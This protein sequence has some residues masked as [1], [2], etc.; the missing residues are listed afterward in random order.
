MNLKHFQRSTR[1]AATGLAMLLALGSVPQAAWAQ[2]S[3]TPNYKDADL[4]Q[5][6]EA[7]S[8][9]T[10]KNFIVD[11]R[12]K[13][14]VT[15][16]SSTPMSPAAF[17]EAFLSILQ[18][19]GFVAVP[20]GDTIKII[21]DA[22]A[23]QIPAN[24]LPSR[25]SSTSD[26]IVTQVVAV[27]NV[28]AAQLV[29]IL[30]PLIPQYGHLAAY[31]A[32][33]M[34]IISDRASNVNRV[35]RIIQR[36]DQQ[37]DES[38]DVVQ[39]QHA[40]A[41]EVVRIIN[42]LYAGGAAGAE[43]AGMPQVK[44]IA[45]ERTNSV[46][47]S[48]EASQRLRLKTL[49]AHLDTPLQSG[50][51]T[52]V[53][54][55]R[56]A[57]AEKIAAK[58]RE[59]I[60]GIAAAAMPTGGA[61]GGAPSVASSGGGDKSVT[62]WAEPQT[63]ALVVTAP[64]KV[65]RSVMAIVDRLDIRRAQ[66][67][68]EAILV[69]MSADKA[70]DLG[71]NWLIAETDS[72]GNSLPAGGFV[73]PV[74]GTGIGEIIQG[75]LDPDSIPGLPSGLTMGL[76]QI[77]SGGTSWAA[78]IRAIGGIGNTNIIAT[79]S[80]VTLDNEEAEIK[81]AQEVPFV[82]G[83][84]TSQGIP[85]T[86]GQVNP[87]QTIQR[88]EVGNILKI[89]PQINEGSSVMLKISQEASSIAASSQQVSTNDLITNKRTITTNVMVED[90]G[91]IVLGGLISDEVRESKSQ[92]PFLG[93]IPIIGE[94]F[95]TRSVDKVKT[96][97][98][99]FIRPRILR[100]GTDAA[101]ESNAKYNYIREQQ[102]GRNGGR[103]PLMP[104]ERQPTLPP[105]EQLVPPELLN[106]ARQA[107]PQGATAAERLQGSSSQEYYLPSDPTTGITHPAPAAAPT[108]PFGETATP[109]APPPPGTTP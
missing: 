58:L 30:R 98:M 45:D 105:L 16:L 94:L 61:A 13:A 67:L 70:M 93:S 21:P 62:I 20:S 96:N 6:I 33:N 18:V 42:S 32:S 51:D 36:I 29:P 78:V 57:D 34:L 74:D 59:Q 87:F 81:I 11:P 38:V 90:G 17:Y 73:Q 31:P 54:Y 76:G 46:L 55:L 4:S 64:P 2:G 92:V 89:T 25:V 102:T 84:Y 5:I 104:S 3:I 107:A 50:G 49:V 7:V 100:D 23:R 10:G 14:Q 66:V 9:V 106:P 19:H 35:M 69:E 63:N 26:E 80:I 22:N 109:P 48:G 97:L 83:Q 39:L 28:S 60:Q 47:V 44:V 103:V 88:E 68:V 91:I 75:V 12:V 8:A 95:K 27:K 101:I 15:M 56:Y 77:V 99:V 52:Q 40:S 108:A 24:D 85:G 71:V 1:L 53:R 41:A 82:T 79:P 72:N 43:G 37:G 86:G 65:M